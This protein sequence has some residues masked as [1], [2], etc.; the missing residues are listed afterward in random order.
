MADPENVRE[1]KQYS[2]L[3]Q[4]LAIIGLSH[5]KHLKHMRSYISNY[6]TRKFLR[7]FKKYPWMRSVSSGIKLGSVPK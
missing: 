2:K 3:L 7:I 5:T 1:I 4:R 6:G